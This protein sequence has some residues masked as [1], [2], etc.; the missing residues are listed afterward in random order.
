[1]RRIF[2]PPSTTFVQTAFSQPGCCT[3]ANQ[4]RQRE[5]EILRAAHQ[6]AEQRAT[7]IINTRRARASV[8]LLA[9]CPA[10]KTPAEQLLRPWRKMSIFYLGC[11]FNVKINGPDI[12]HLALFTYIK[13]PKR[14]RGLHLQRAPQYRATFLVPRQSSPSF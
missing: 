9:T 14:A 5:R 3:R 1:M 13:V 4:Q 8:S 12:F 6:P 11:S 7:D 2:P 10:R